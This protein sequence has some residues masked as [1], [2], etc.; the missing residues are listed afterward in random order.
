MRI[1]LIP[2]RSS[3]RCG[4]SRALPV[5]VVLLVAAACSGS[6]GGDSRPRVVASFFPLAEAAERVG[7]DTVEVDDLTPAGTEPH[8]VELAA[9][10]VDALLDADLVV[11]L[12]GGFQPAVE[13]VVDERDGTSVDVLDAV[14]SGDDPHVWLDPTAMVHIVDAVA[15]GIAEVDPDRAGDVRADADRYRAELEQLDADLAAQLD[16]CRR[17]LI[18]SAHDAFGELARRYGLRTEAVTGISPEAEPDAGRLAE[19]ADLVEREGVT[20]VFTEEL[21]P[22]EV[23]E[24]LAR[25]ADVD[26]AVLDPIESR[27]DGGYVAAM[28]RNGDAL[29]L[30]LGCR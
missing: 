13:D 28:R 19:L 6:G 21:V 26:T 5:I 25:E 18:V 23:A 14:D 24:A 4:V 10:E 11:Y 2:V 3:R 22:P 29:A 1:V 9:D 17:D 27:P 20:T 30:A 15:D 16:D 7:G 8:D 12:G